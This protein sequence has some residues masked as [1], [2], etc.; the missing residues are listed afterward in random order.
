M[1]RGY[2]Y[3]ISFKNTIDIYIGKTITNIKRRFTS[4]KSS[5][6]VYEY[7]KNKL[8]NDWSNVYI[9]IIDSVSMEEDLTYILKHPSNIIME[10]GYRKYTWSCKTNIELLNYRLNIIEAFH[11]NN[12]IYNYNVINKRIPSSFQLYETYELFTYA[13]IL[14]KKKND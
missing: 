9:D 14:F 2:I 3:I 13:K 8:D 10:N 7:V 5:G 12:Y 11:I 6:A 1:L 4:H